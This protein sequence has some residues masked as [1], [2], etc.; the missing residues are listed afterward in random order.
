[1]L[2]L[3]NVFNEPVRNARVSW[4][5]GCGHAPD[6]RSGTT[7]DHGRVVLESID[8]TV[9]AEWWISGAG[10][11]TEPA[12]L[13]WNEDRTQGIVRCLP[14][15]ARVGVLESA[16]GRPLADHYVGQPNR[17]RGP[18]TRT[19][20]QGR[21]RLFGASDSEL[22]V[23]GPDGAELGSFPTAL[24]GFPRVIRVAPPRKRSSVYE[25]TVTGKDGGPTGSVLVTVVRVSDGWNESLR[26]DAEGKLRLST[27]ADVHI[28]RVGG[29][30]GLYDPVDVPALPP[31]ESVHALG[32]RLSKRGTA[33]ILTAKAEPASRVWI[34][35][36]SS[37]REVT[38][39][40]D[41]V[42]MPSEECVLRCWT[43][44]AWSFHRVTDSDREPG[45]VIRLDRQ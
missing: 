16:D 9:E 7:D 36:R 32:V 18:W 15:P 25:L 30:L 27:S 12:E 42:P 19:D 6:S 38:D 31:L 14:S 45:A 22:Y 39:E 24:P 34:A 13:Q 3:V 17:H 44:Q 20:D 29:G 43:D 4:I 28:L 40:L 5:L 1:M 2:T 21:F 8:P 10:V 26:T 23:R 11:L 41:A 33:R 35:T 37:E